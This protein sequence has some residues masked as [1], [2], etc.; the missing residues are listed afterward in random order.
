LI[1]EGG[2]FFGAFLG[3]KKGH[4]LGGQKV[5]KIGQKRGVFG[6]YKNYIL[7]FRINGQKKL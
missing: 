6:G 7:V 1:R 3:V 4:F 5:P 2:G